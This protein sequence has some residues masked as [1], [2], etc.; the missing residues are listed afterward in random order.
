[1][2]HQVKRRFQLLALSQLFRV[3]TAY[4]LEAVNHSVRL[5]AVENPAIGR[6]CVGT[7]VRGKAG[8]VPKNLPRVGVDHVNP[9][10]SSRNRHALVC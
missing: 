7:G 2:R 1:M 6:D 5:R 3:C 4:R 8:A 9:A 10:K